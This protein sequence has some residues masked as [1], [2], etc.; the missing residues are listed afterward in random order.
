V[1]LCLH[2]YTQKDILNL[3]IIMSF[4]HGCQRSGMHEIPENF[5]PATTTVSQRQLALQTAQ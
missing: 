3:N 2:A 5:P 4:K 1:F